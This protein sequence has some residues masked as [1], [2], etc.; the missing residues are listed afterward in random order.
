MKRSIIGSV[1]LLIGT[2]AV[3]DNLQGVDRLLCATGPIVACF[4]DGECIPVLASEAEVPTFVVID[5]KSKI[6]STTKASEENRK[7]AIANVSRT[8]G[9]I[10]LQGVENGRAYSFVIDEQSGRATVAVSRDGL[11][12]SVFGACTDADL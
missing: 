12:V 4:E 6:M 8:D 9:F 1:G 5:I 2:A 3:A 7:T 10:Y 11:S